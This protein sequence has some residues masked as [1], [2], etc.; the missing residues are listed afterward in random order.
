MPD[1][2]LTTADDVLAGIDLTGRQI[3]VTGAAAGLGLSAATSFARAGADVLLVG[4][5][6]ARLE[7]A[8]QAVAASGSGTV[9]VE[10]ADLADLNAVAELGKRLAGNLS[11]LDVLVLNAGVMAAPLERSRRAMRCSSRSATSVT[12]C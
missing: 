7:A 12:T 3:V 2:F 11:R 8:R 4:R 10:H 5:D 6:G 9:S 1:T